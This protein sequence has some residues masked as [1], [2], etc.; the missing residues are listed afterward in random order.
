VT[1]SR[2]TGLH[3]DAETVFRRWGALAESMEGAAVAHVCALHRI[4]FLE[5]R[6]ISNL[7]GDRDREAWQVQ[8]AVAGAGRAALAVVAALPGLP[9]AAAWGVAGEA[10]VGNRG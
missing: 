6:G 4:A 2:A 9:L 7:V 10:C 5:I 1:T 8:R 3:A